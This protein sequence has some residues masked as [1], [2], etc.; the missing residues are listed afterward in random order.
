M[1]QMGR[2]FAVAEP[3]Y[4]SDCKNEIEHLVN[5]NFVDLD[6]VWCLWKRVSE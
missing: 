1:L 3:L 5:I 4:N 6:K 2:G